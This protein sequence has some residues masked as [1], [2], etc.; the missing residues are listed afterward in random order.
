LQAWADSIVCEFLRAR[1]EIFDFRALLTSRSQINAKGERDKKAF[2]FFDV[3]DY[4]RA[5]HRDLLNVAQ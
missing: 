5:G 3:Y 2:A 4:L 1:E